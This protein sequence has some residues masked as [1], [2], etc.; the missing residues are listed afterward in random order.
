VTRWMR[1]QSGSIL[2]RKKEDE[3]RSS[4]A[5]D[6]SQNSSAIGSSFSSVLGAPPSALI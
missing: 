1:W 6:I 2:E 4:W 5:V 3:A